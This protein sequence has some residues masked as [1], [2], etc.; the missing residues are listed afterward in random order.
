M[1]HAHRPRYAAKSLDNLVAARSANRVVVAAYVV[2]VAAAL[3]EFAGRVS[4]RVEMGEEAETV[5]G[6]ADHRCMAVRLGDLFGSAGGGV[7]VVSGPMSISSTAKGIEPAG[8][9]FFMFI[10]LLNVVLRFTVL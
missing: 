8:A 3:V 4:G 10:M 2:Q 5:Q 7:V 9:I 6:I 1:G